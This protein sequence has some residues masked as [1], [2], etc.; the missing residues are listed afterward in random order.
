VQNRLLCATYW[1]D[2]KLRLKSREIRIPEELDREIEREAEER[3]KSWSAAAVELLEE[4]IRFRRTT[5]IGF[6]DGPSGRRA[7]IAGTGIDVW[8]VV[9]VWLECGRDYDEL[10]VNFDWL[11]DSQLRAAISYYTLYPVEIDGRLERERRW[12]PERIRREL[13]FSSPGQPES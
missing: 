11:N 4:A 9:A 10:K 3:G 2:W 7:V 13:P 1:K 8:E 12:I 5:G 6:A